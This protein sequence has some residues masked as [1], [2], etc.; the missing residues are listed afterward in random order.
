M[1]YH[2]YSSFTL[3]DGRIMA[4]WRRTDGRRWRVEERIVGTT[5]S[6]PAEFRSYGECEA[7]IDQVQEE[8]RR[9]RERT[10]ERTRTNAAIY[11]TIFGGEEP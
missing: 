2:A 3:D 5:A 7:W 1:T 6:K 8:A 9:V 4:I 11:H 10:P